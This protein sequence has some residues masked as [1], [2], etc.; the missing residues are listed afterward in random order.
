MMMDVADRVAYRVDAHHHVWQLARGDYGWLTP[1]LAAIH[2]DFTLDDLSPLLAHAGIEATV[3]V[4]AAPTL[5]ETEF[6][7][8]TAAHG[9]GC[10]RG[11]VGW[12]DLA[13]PDAVATLSRLARDPLL[14]SIRPML[15]DLRDPE[16]IL[17]AEVGRAL[18]ALPGFG[19]RFDALVKPAQMP[20]LL[21]M[22]DR[23]PDLAVVVDHGAKPP[24]ATGEWRP[25]ADLVDAIARHPHVHC[26]LSGLVT[27]AQPD[28]TV[29]SL[30]P[31]VDH[32]LE[33]FGT[34]RLMWGSDWPVVNL[35]GG[36][37]RWLAATDLLL[38]A[39]D[40]AGRA[41]IFGGNAARFYGLES[42]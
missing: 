2:R 11:V 15:Q 39:L 6:L 21:R 14:K 28:W 29:E 42:T 33:C 3:L 23:H 10:V 40:A 25:W 20:A 30:R 34:A 18:A 22:L 4:Q 37:T 19:L 8:A 17:R 27:E 26:K 1:D 24:I 32:V 36:Y 12:A 7:L 38:G 16:W 35:A 9:N 5:A 41:A 31:W 13:A